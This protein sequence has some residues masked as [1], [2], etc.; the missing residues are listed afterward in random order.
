[1]HSEFKFPP[2]WSL[3][4]VFSLLFVLTSCIVRDNPCDPFNFDNGD[5]LDT[6]C[7][8]VVVTSKPDDTTDFPIPPDS[9]DSLNASDSLIPVLDSLQAILVKMSDSALADYDLLS[10]QLKNDVEIK[11]NGE[12]LAQQNG[13]RASKNEKVSNLAQL[14]L[15]SCYTLKYTLDSLQTFDS[16]VFQLN[17]EN[18]EKR[19]KEISEKAASTL[20]FGFKTFSADSLKLAAKEDTISL[21]IENLNTYLLT[22]N[23]F[24][25]LLWDRRKEF[26][27]LLFA[28]NRKV[29]EV[30]P[31]IVNFNDSIQE[32]FCGKA[33]S[34]Y[35]VIKEALEYIIPGD[36]VR[37]EGGEI[38][39]DA[40]LQVVTSGDSLNPIVFLGDP[41]KQTRLI[42]NNS[43]L[44]LISEA[45]N[46]AFFFIDFVGSMQ[47]G[48]RIEGNSGPIRFENC[49][50]ISNST[51][52][53]F[54]SNVDLSLTNCRIM[55]NKKSGIKV[56]ST[57]KPESRWEK[58][59]FENVLVANNASSGIEGISIKGTI[60]NSTITNNGSANDYGMALEVPTQNLTLSNT[61]LTFNGGPEIFTQEARA[62]L[63]TFLNTNIYDDSASL[64]LLSPPDS[65]LIWNQEGE[66]LRI[67]PQYV[68]TLN[69]E[70]G[71]EELDSIGYRLSP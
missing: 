30:N 36:T 28:Q 38:L 52:G 25:S 14:N 13:I 32:N 18:R 41:V 53:I 68:D 44:M 26:E 17:Y 16:L 62:N 60:N 39:L 8:V 64:P 51:N 22:A 12:N 7:R 48:I 10:K 1:M 59:T 43:N 71:A 65:N 56:V 58:I 4:L 2:I 67:A 6:Y 29:A 19:R 40:K 45:K 63:V 55:G 42:P 66:P 35:E 47:D 70:P 69:F 57:D 11:A 61:I 3:W 5:S 21:K 37:L 31:K 9:T 33:L 50:F 27:A 15:V 46:I 54:A 23:H 49:N 34:S 24:D 20:A